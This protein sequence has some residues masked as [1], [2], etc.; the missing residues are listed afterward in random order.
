MRHHRNGACEQGAVGF[1][2]SDG[3]SLVAAVQLKFGFPHGCDNVI[4][5]IEIIYSRNSVLYTDFL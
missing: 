1:D 3:L 5:L 4:R 2:K